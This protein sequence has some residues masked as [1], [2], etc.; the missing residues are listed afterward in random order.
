MPRYFCKAPSGSCVYREHRLSL[1]LTLEIAPTGRA[2]AD[3][4]GPP[5]ADPADEHRESALGSAAHHPSAQCPFSGE[6]WTSRMTVRMSA[7][8]LKRTSIKGE[9]LDEKRAPVLARAVHTSRLKY[10]SKGSH[11][12]A[13]PST[14]AHSIWVS[15]LLLYP[16]CLLLKSASLWCSSRSMACS[17]CLSWPLFHLA[18]LVSGEWSI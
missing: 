6:Q 14:I 9:F 1:L 13:R 7:N 11:G 2:A 5:C 17:R 12:G 3:R 10:D 18:E 4:D 16:P 15:R 8:D